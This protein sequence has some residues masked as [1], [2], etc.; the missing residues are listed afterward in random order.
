MEF[1]LDSLPRVKVCGAMEFRIQRDLRDHWHSPA[2]QSISIINFM[3]PVKNESKE[4]LSQA[5]EIMIVH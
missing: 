1:G 3:F 4:N 5:Q 2:N